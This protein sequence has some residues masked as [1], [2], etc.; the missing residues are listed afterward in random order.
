MGETKY[1]FRIGERVLY[2]SKYSGR[3]F[4][5]VITSFDPYPPRRGIEFIQH[6]WIGTAWD[7]VSHFSK[8]QCVGQQL[9][10]KFMYE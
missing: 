1:G 8:I 5:C 7:T 3:T 4:V 6:G 9:L 2:T 10:F